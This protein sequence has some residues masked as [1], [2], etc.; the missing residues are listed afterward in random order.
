MAEYMKVPGTSG[1]SPTGRKPGMAVGTQ[2]HKGDANYRAG[3]TQR[4]A[5]SQLGLKRQ[6]NAQHR[7]ENENIYKRN[8]YDGPPIQVSKTHSDG[9][10][11]IPGVNRPVYSAPAQ[12]QGLLQ[13]A[14]R[15]WRDRR[16]K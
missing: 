16:K 8:T 15:L 11:R 1:N 12:K 3:V 13:K 10:P 9:S 4:N 2:G 14:S 5:Q 7:R 6:Q